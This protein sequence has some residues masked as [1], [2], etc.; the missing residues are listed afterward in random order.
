MKVVMTILQKIFE[1]HTNKA[2]FFLEISNAWMKNKLRGSIRKI[3][4]NIMKG[5]LNTVIN[6]KWYFTLPNQIVT[7][8]SFLVFHV[9]QNEVK[10]NEPA[11]K[12]WAHTFRKFL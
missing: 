1:E 10:R 2:H 11:L 8:S 7:F 3:Y 4:P 12:F 9:F 6:E 5:W